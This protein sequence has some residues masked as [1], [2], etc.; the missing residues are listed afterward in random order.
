[1][2][3]CGAALILVLAL[4]C[5]CS[6]AQ[7][8]SVPAEPQPA[9]P[10]SVPEA[11]EPAAPASVPDA[12]ETQKPAPEPDSA[13][14]PEPEEAHDAPDQVL[15]SGSYTAA[16]Y[17]RS[18]RQEDCRIEC[19]EYVVSDGVTATAFRAEGTGDSRFFDRTV[20]NRGGGNIWYYNFQSS[21]WCCTALGEGTFASPVTVVEL[22]SGETFFIALPRTFLLRENSSMEYLPE[23]DG[24]LHITQ[25]ADGLRMTVD[26]C[27]LEEGRVT[28]ALVLTA[29]DRLMDWTVSNCAKAW[30]SYVKDGDFLWCYDGYYARSPYNYI[31][32]G[33]NCY[34]CCTASYCIKGFLSRTPPCREAPA[35]VILMLDTLSRRQNSYGFWPTASACQWLLDDHGIGAVFYDT[36]FST[37][38][39]EIYLE[40][41]R[42]FGGS[43]FEETID[44]YLTFYSR[45]ADTCHVS[46]ET[47]GWLI[48]DYWHPSERAT[49]HTSLNHQAA[50]CLAL[51]RAADLLNRKDLRELADRM[52]LAIEDTGSGWVMPDHNLYY[53]IQPDGAFVEGDYPYLTYNDLFYLRKYLSGVGRDD[54]DTLTY[55]MGEKLQWMQAQGVTGYETG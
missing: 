42:K 35:L 43:M 13:P 20:E 39:L 51:Y 18:L 27:G 41:A 49:P 26:G 37:D 1:M 7:V 14:E 23:L 36:R 6:P 8:P 48:P 15:S 52:L 53:S 19:R 29:P 47:G 25:T 22:A 30:V 10:A 55:L 44:R 34:Y 3:L 54:T 50:E 38:L 5:A 31:P 46:T 17:C 32:T 16:V 9:A 28:D 33:T 11:P 2:Q 21:D 45:I 24:A 4:L 40:A 12:P